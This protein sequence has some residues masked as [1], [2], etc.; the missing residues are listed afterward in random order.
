[1]QTWQRRRAGSSKVPL[2]GFGS[3]TGIAGPQRFSIHRAAGAS[4]ARLPTA[5]TCFNQLDL[6]PYDCK[7]QL[8]ERLVM[9]IHEGA[10]G[11]G[12]A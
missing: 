11:F 9:A 6:P 8:R 5:H 4:A 10:T 1:M 7:E 3:L 12:F 2:G